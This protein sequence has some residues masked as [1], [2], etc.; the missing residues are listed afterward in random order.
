MIRGIGVDLVEVSRISALI[1]RFGARAEQRIFTPRELRTCRRR[2]TTAGTVECLAA[3]F[4]AKEAFLK[5]VGGASGAA[6]S[7][8]E[9]EVSLRDT[10]EPELTV[11]GAA[12]TRLRELAEG[13]RPRVHLSLSHDGGKAVAVVVVEDGAA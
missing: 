8:R 1:E 13:S 7:W 9:M 4:A 11:S 6:V 3:R 12:A 2:S 10:G 5:A